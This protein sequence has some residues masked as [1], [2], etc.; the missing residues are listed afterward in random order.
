M[1]IVY[2]AH[3]YR[4]ED[5]VLNRHFGI[6]IERA[7]NM[8]INF[9]PP[10]NKVNDSKLSQN[11]RSCDGMVT[12]L[13]WRDTGPSQYILY[14][15]ALALRGRKPLLVFMDDRLSHDVLPGWIFQ[16]R[17]SHRTYFRQAREHSHALNEL[18]NYMGDPPPA[19]YEPSS[20]QRACGLVGF[21][22][23]DRPT[24][25][26]VL[27]FLEAQRYRS[28]NLDSIDISNPL[29]FENLDQLARLHVALHFADA[30]TKPSVFWAGGL[31]NSA[32]PL[33]AVTTNPDYPF[34][35][36][37][38]AEFQPRMA[39]TNSSPPLEEVLR[40]EFDLFEQDFLKAEDVAT[41]E[42]YTLQ[43]L[44]SSMAGRYDARPQHSG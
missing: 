10:F 39:N 2:W 28:V 41:I 17:F 31:R 43:V 6:L 9:D 25:S 38:P 26:I 12:V 23:L 33:I 15:I 27:Q 13:T 5:A 36:K 37:F 7:A 21:G 29:E 1:Q 34:N 44:A 18:K 16:R 24:Q 20:G 11:L 4:E 3:S 35:G 30:R 22:S 19:R 42:R 32:I 40:E 14:E 8:V